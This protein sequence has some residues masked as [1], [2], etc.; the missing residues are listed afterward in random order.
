MKRFNWL[1]ENPVTRELASQLYGKPRRRRPVATGLRRVLRC[2]ESLEPRLLLATFLVTNTNNSGAGSLRAAI[3][4]ANAS[5]EFDVINFLIAGPGPHVISPQPTS[6]DPL[7]VAMPI[8]SPML[9]NG[10][11]QAGARP[12]TLSE[13]NNADI[14]IRIDGALAGAGAGG[15]FIDGGGATIQG[16]A[17][18]R[19]EDG[20]I[21]RGGGG[22]NTIAGNFIGLDPLRNPLGNL[23]HGVTIEGSPGNRVGGTDPAA[24]NVISANGEIGVRL[25]GSASVDNVIRGNYIGTDPSGTLD[26]GNG[27]SL[28]AG[29]SGIE[30]G[31]FNIDMGYASRTVIGGAAPGAGNLIS[32]NAGSGIVLLGTPSR[33]NVIQGNYIGTTA[34]GDAPL[35]NDR[36]GILL[37]LPL[38]QNGQPASGTASNNTI[39]GTEP[40]AGNVIS[41]N[42]RHGIS[43]FGP[44]NN[45]VVQGNFIGTDAAGNERLGNGLEGIR[46]AHDADIIDGP[47]DNTIGGTAAGAGNVISGNG[48]NGVAVLGAGTQSNELL[49]NRIGTNAAGTAAI[50]NSLHGV[51][52]NVAT[53]GG[54][55][56]SNTFIGGITAAS[57]NI[58]SGNGQAGVAI[59]GTGAT[60]NRVQGNYI[61]TNMTGT[62]AIPNG[63]DGVRLGDDSSGAGPSGNFIGGTLPGAGNVIS[64]NTDSGVEIAG[65]TTSGNFIEGNLIGTN[66]AGNAA[67][68]NSRI[69]V[70]ID[71][72]ENTRIGGPSA[73]ARN[74]I[75][76]NGN[77][78][79]VIS[80]NPTSNSVIQGNYIGV[81]SDGVSP[82]GNQ[83]AGV[84][85]Q[86]ASNNMIG[87]S[88]VAAANVIAHNVQ[89]GVLIQSGSTRNTVRLNSIHSNEYL[90]ID[91]FADGENINDLN[92]TDDGPNNRQNSPEIV[93]FNLYGPKVVGYFDSAPNTT[94]TFDFYSNDPTVL[95]LGE[96]QRYVATRTLTTDADGYVRF[97]FILPVATP[98]G[99]FITVTATD[100]D[101]NTSEFSH[102]ADTDG[103]LDEWEMGEQVDGDG[104]GVG[105]FS[106]STPDPLHKDLYVDVDAM[107]TVHSRMPGVRFDMTFI[108]N[109][110]AP[111]PNVLNPD[112]TAGIK[113]HF[114]IDPAPL[115]PSKADEV[116]SMEELRVVKAANFGTAGERTNPALIAAKRM[117]HRYALFAPPDDK[118]GGLSWRYGHEFILM[119]GPGSTTYLDQLFFHELGHALGLDHGGGDDVGFKPNY[120][121]A[122]NGIWANKP[123][124][125]GAFQDSWE[126]NYSDARFP[127]LDENHL[128]ES[129]GIGGH[130]AHFLHTGPLPAEVVE[131]SGPVDWNRDG[132]TDDI[133]VTG[134]DLNRLVEDVNGDGR[135]N[136]VDDTTG[137]ILI[138]HDDW[139]N[140]YLNFRHSIHYRGEFG[141][142]TASFGGQAAQAEP[143][144]THELIAQIHD[145]GYANGAPRISGLPD[146]IVDELQTL[147][148]TVPATDPENDALT[149]VL[150]PGAPAD[151]SI[152]A[153]TGQFTWITDASDGPGEYVITVRVTDSGSGRVRERN[154]GIVVNDI[155]QA[156]DYN[157]N[158]TVEA[159]DYVIWRK[160]LGE[161]KTPFTRAD[162]SGNGIIDQADYL[163]WRAN[164]G[165]TLPPA[166]SG[167]STIAATAMAE[168][169]T[170]TPPLFTRPESLAITSSF[171]AAANFVQSDSRFIGSQPSRQDHQTV[172]LSHDEALMAWL[173]SKPQGTRRECP[174]D[175]CSDEI[176]GMNDNSAPEEF[177]NAFDSV[178]AQQGVFT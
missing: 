42:T 84:R 41:G 131:E 114:E 173:T 46:L 142:E 172:A 169:K 26:R 115:L 1:K 138:G 98:L 59:F 79:I 154:Y 45:N 19:F 33:D 47:T 174:A 4:E 61:G 29:G 129:A 75:S 139:S 109:N 2:P 156:G 12:N 125:P 11:S 106:L 64:G 39:G 101:G 143:G 82:L 60:G 95:N 157:A 130:F 66:A 90:G 104:D 105:D 48:Q 94:Y 71:R 52:I 159:A 147:S 177:A 170:L 145:L 81:K 68:P 50:A 14:R 110:K 5:A 32:A 124:D 161:S 51:T 35:G 167:S 78:G 168:S 58:I 21:I 9:I 102:D 100:P 15:L 132:D 113:L 144:F 165:K 24:R 127:N 25:V 22:G 57:R 27:E 112:G 69:G 96:G 76:G 176:G 140:L 122:M 153:N 86:F 70:L 178:F 141:Q 120:H 30:V 123:P 137:E 175:A 134:I 31:V 73:P 136:A 111:A 87:G 89:E 107:G 166:V 7:S 54:N 67:V 160:T 83:E 55:A 56:A 152:N 93:L 34:T 37:T 65:T 148:F 155:S 135:V 16:L 126:I 8:S 77:A 128:D 103:L 62:A 40:G 116:D 117:T 63:N 13:G 53:P 43:I 20:V 23:G 99:Q 17:I 28:G 36:N 162:G 163:I 151:A 38:L 92:D 164:F 118:L 171:L 74:V 3:A 121:S 146:Q 80:N 72:A 88:E 10:Y 44:A 91:L 149:F 97:E 119:G 133:I 158:G 18:T 108:F 85:I 6:A 150:A 49:G